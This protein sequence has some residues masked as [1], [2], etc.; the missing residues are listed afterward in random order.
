MVTEEDREGAVAGEVAVEEWRRELTETD[1]RTGARTGGK[2]QRVD[3]VV[4]VHDV[5]SEC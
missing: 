2:R 5:G 1:M 3:K 4:T